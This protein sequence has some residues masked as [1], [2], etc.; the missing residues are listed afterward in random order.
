[1]AIYHWSAQVIG[2][3]DGRSSVAAAAYRLGLDLTDE[4]TGRRHDYT[5]KSGVHGWEQMTP[6]GAPA[7][8]SDPAACWNSVEQ[9]E[10]RKDAQLCREINV[11]L[12][13]EL[14][15]DQMKDL[16]RAW[17]QKNCV[18]RG[19]V[20]TVAWHDLDSE[21]PHAHIMLALRKIDGDGWSKHKAREW[22]QKEVLQQWRETWA[23]EANRALEAAGS[24]ERIDHRSL[25]DQ[26]LDRVPTRHMGP[27]ATAMERRG[28]K[29]ER[30]RVVMPTP[31]SMDHARAVAERKREQAKKLTPEQAYA[32]EWKAKDERLAELQAA[33]LKALER[34]Q[35][36]AD[37]RRLEREAAEAVYAATRADQA[38]QRQMAAAQEQ[39]AREKRQ[40]VSQWQDRHWLRTRLG[41]VPRHIREAESAAKRLLESAERKRA[42]A[43]KAEERARKEAEAVKASRKAE[44][45]ALAKVREVEAARQRVADERAKH[46]QQSPAAR[47]RAQQELRGALRRQ[48]YE[49]ERAERWA[50]AWT[51]QSRQDEH[52]ARQRRNRGPSL[53][54]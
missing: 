54:M 16:T 8:M 44:A 23:E 4:R 29:P 33:G 13:R 34:R 15:R 22:N 18:D 40:S 46:W 21:N 11:A 48:Q 2:R 52:E 30:Q 5:R 1:M 19:M 6:A 3:S 17:V 31:A 39:S 38:A 41:L 43:D 14:T 49:R 9:F 25:K 12:P 35:K 27:K 47:E 28:E 45:E 36:E 53:S 42:R 50:Q 24:R 51:P 32:A 7:W 37:Q 20:A 10:K 26:G